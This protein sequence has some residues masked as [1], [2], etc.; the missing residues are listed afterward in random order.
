MTDHVV[1]HAAHPSLMRDA[2]AIRHTIRFLRTGA[3]E[4]ASAGR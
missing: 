3:F 4:H 2:R 1:V